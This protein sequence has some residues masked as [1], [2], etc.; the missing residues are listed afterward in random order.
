MGF[1]FPALLWALAAIA[2]PIIIHLFYFRRYKKVYFSST[3]FLKEVKE[4]QKKA[5]RLQQ[6]LVLASRIAAVIFLVMAF[7][8]PFWGQRSKAGL[9]ASRSVVIYI[10]NTYSMGLQSGGAELLGTAKDAAR[11]ILENM[12]PGDRVMLLSNELSGS[13]QRWLNPQEALPLLDE[14]RLSSSART[15][16]DILSRLTVIFNEA[17][18]KDYFAYFISDFQTYSMPEKWPDAGFE[19]ILMPVQAKDQSN[20][21]IDSCWMADPV[22]YRQAVNKMVVR[23]KNSGNRDASSQI[24]LQLDGEVRAIGDVQIAANSSKIDT[25]SFSIRNTGWQKGQIS[26]QDYPVTFDNQMYFAFEAAASNKVLL[27][28]EVSSGRAVYNVFQTDAHFAVDKLEALRTDLSSLPSYNLVVLN[29]LKSLSPAMVSALQ[30]Y[31]VNGGSLYIIP[32]E[33]ANVSSYNTLQS[34]LGVGQFAEKI[35]VPA[36]VQSLNEKEPIVQAAFE[37]FPRNLDLPQVKQYFPISSAARVVERSVLKLDNGRPFLN[38][39]QVEGGVVYLQASALQSSSTDFSAKAIFP[40]LIYNMAVFKASPRPLYYEIGAPNLVKGLEA[41]A[42][43][44]QVVRMRSGD[45]EII[46]PVQPVGNRLSVSI[47][48]DL[49]RDGIYEILRGEKVLDVIAANFSRSESE[50]LFLSDGALKERYPADNVSVAKVTDVMQG[51][52][53]AG[54]DSATPLWKLCL[55]LALIFLIVETLLLRFATPKAAA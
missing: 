20:L 22:V 24:S 11:K 33:E 5:G 9:S 39:Y 46:P 12:G 8:Q 54:L 13:M 55:I 19:T 50:M 23:I 27:M 42:G 6:L 17:P 2:I 36:R 35:S 1:V 41:V 53:V 49:E 18:G 48:S 52:S 38:S 32:A 3:R 31:V 37:S 25:L 43:T 40:P 10:D 21:Y 30:S 16:S 34:S 4:K 26:I 51:A 44:E 28:E 14:V 7:T 45:F 29:E 15:I 47:P